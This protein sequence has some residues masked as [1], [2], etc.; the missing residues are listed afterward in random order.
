MGVFADINC[1]FSNVQYEKDVIIRAKCGHCMS[2]L[3]TKR[4]MNGRCKFE[5]KL[6]AKLNCI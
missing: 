4:L 1:I 6:K 5:H 2:I 3:I